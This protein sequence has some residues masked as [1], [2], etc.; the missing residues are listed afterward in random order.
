MTQDL[1][2]CDVGGGEAVGGVRGRAWPR[3]SHVGDGYV[4]LHCTSLSPPVYV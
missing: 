2:Q 1:L 3:V 4:G